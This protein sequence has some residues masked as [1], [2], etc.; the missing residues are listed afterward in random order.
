[1]LLVEIFL[2]QFWIRPL[3]DLVLMWFFRLGFHSSDFL[4]L[5]LE[6]D[7]ETFLR[8]KHTYFDLGLNWPCLKILCIGTLTHSDDFL[9]WVHTMVSHVVP[10][11]EAIIPLLCFWRLT[12]MIQPKFFWCKLSLFLWWDVLIG[13]SFVKLRFPFCYTLNPDLSRPVD[14]FR[15]LWAVFKVLTSKCQQVF[16]AN[17]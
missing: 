15:I 10:V 7:W 13:S 1:M 17:V 11:L 4:S 5:D 12:P 16:K 9:L 3:S 8:C 14:L 2:N 6:I